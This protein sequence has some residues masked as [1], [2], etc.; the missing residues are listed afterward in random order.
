MIGSCKR[1]GCPGEG[2]WIPVF[3]LH[4]KRGDKPL[5]AR[6]PQVEQ[7]ELHKDQGT[8]EHFLSPEGWDKLQKH[9][10]EAGKGRFVQKL[11]T[12]TWEPVPGGGAECL[13]F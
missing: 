8:I 10:R 12:L 5:R 3:L 7:C 2:I 11:T 1:D 9:L 4:A 13:P 6:L